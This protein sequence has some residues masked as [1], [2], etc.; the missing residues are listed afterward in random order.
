MLDYKHWT[1]KHYV[2]S[3]LWLSGEILQSNIGLKAHVAKK[4]HNGHFDD[5]V[6]TRNDILTYQK[7]LKEYT[8]VRGSGGTKQRLR[9]YC[10]ILSGKTYSIAMN[11]LQKKEKIREEDVR[12][13]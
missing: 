2:L 10:L 8:D 3:G 5:S 12:K 4:K 9:N 11:L 1:T 13:L 6:I 7:Y